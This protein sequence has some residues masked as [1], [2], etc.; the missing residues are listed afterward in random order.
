[1]SNRRIP[2]SEVAARFELRGRTR[3]CASLAIVKDRDVLG[4]G[5]SF[6]WFERFAS[7]SGARS[8]TG[9]DVN[10]AAL[11]VAKTNVPEATLIRASALELPFADAEFDVVAMFDVLEHLP[12]GSE[13]RALREIRRVLRRD[14]ILALSTPNRHWLATVLDP[15]YYFGHRHYAR[16]Q[17]VSLVVD[18]GFGIDRVAIRGRLFDQMDVLSYYAWRELF[19]REGHPFRWIRARADQEWSDPHGW[20]SILVVA[21]RQ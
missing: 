10:S 7:D 6:G 5:V 17:L 13:A 8:V 20:N 19:G 1:M 15:A 4:I 12:N 11:E 14:G 21:T 18:A 3:A 2:L 16:R 9:V